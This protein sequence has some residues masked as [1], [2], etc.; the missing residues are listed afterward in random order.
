MEK[1]GWLA[2][3]VT[4]RAAASAMELVPNP[5]REA[6]HFT[7]WVVNSLHES[8]QSVCRVRTTLDLS[9]QKEAERLLR[10]GVEALEDRSC[11]GGAAVVLSTD[12]CEVLALVGSPDFSSPDAGEVNAALVRRQPGSAVKPFTYA[13][14]FTGSLRPSSILHDLPTD[15]PTMTGL[16]SPRNYAETF[17][18]PVSAKMALANSWNVPSV[19]VLHITGIEDVARTFEAVGLG[20]GDIER[21]GLGI[22]LGVAEVRLLDLAAA[23]ATLGRGGTWVEPI[24]IASAWDLNRASLILPEPKRNEAIDPDACAWINEILS[25]PAARAAA[26]GRGGPLEFSGPVGAKTGTSSDWRDAWAL[27]YTRRHVV[28]VWMGNPDGSPTESVTGALGPAFVAQRLLEAI[29]PEES[30]QPFVIPR[31][32]QMRP[33][34]PLSGCAPGPHCPQRD[35]APFRIDDPPLKACPV[36]GARTI[37]VATGR[38][39]R[40]CTP[41]DRLA[42][43]LFA[44]LPPRFALWLH[45]EGQSSAP[46]E[47][48]DCLCGRASCC[49]FDDE[50]EPAGE[51]SEFVIIRPARGSVYT[52][53]PTLCT[54][55]QE[56]ALEAVAP[57]GRRVRWEIDGR[58]VGTTLGRHRIFWPLEPGAHDVRAWIPEEDLFATRRFVVYSE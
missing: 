18:G 12:P 57:P 6:P 41:K 3:E 49:G 51:P 21:V 13:C 27:L 42:P 23:Y 34:C 14:A 44:E 8:R 37:D 52:I 25:D 50:R 2:P 55:Q 32:T 15:Y 35:W 28:A 24:A 43:R 58:E 5:D 38:L 22:A 7:S 39:A 16:F 40:R 47:L 11:R 33:V 30:M 10:D 17:S 46:T 26:F 45:G 1:L 19:E 48:T 56:L 54:D 9:I 36:H 31:T 53:D 29:E 4:Q 20:C